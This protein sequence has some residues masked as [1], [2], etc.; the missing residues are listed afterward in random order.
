MRNPPLVLTIED[1]E[2]VRR[3]IASY[4]TD[5][6]Y[7][8]IEADNGRAGLQRI[9]MDKP[10]VVLCDLRMPELDGLFV[11]AEIAKFLPDT[12]VIVVSGTGDVQDAVHSLHLGAWDYIMKPIQDMAVLEDSIRKALERARLVAQNREYRDTL[13]EKNQQ[14]AHSLEKLEE[15]KNAADAANRAKGTFLANMSHEIRTPMNAIIGM[16]DLLADTPLNEEQRDFLDTIRISSEALLD[17]LNDILD[18]SKIESGKMDLEPVPFDLRKH[19]ERIV[20]TIAQQADAKN[21]ELGLLINPETPP[22]V[23]GDP[24]RIRQILLNLVNNA[25]KFTSEGEVVVHVFPEVSEG[26]KTTGKIRFEVSDTGIGIP[27]DRIP[28]LFQPFTQVDSS[29]TRRFGGTGLGLAISFRLTELMG[30]KIGIISELDRGSTFWFTIPLPETHNEPGIEYGPE[31]VDLRGTRV[32]VVDD[33]RTNRHILRT[34]LE[35]WGCAV[36]EAVS[37]GDALLM[38][39]EAIAANRPFRMALVDYQ[40]P[41]M[42]GET[43]TRTIKGDEA[44]KEVSVVLLTSV[45]TRNT[46]KELAGIGFEGALCKPLKQSMLRDCMTAILSLRHGASTGESTHFVTEATIGRS[47]LSRYRILV[48]EDV[49]PNQKVIQQLLARAGYQSVIVSNGREALDQLAGETF[50]L[51]LMDCQM[52]VM[53]GY[54]ATRRLRSSEEGTVRHT[55]VIAMTASVMKADRERCFSVGMDDFLSKPVTRTQ[56]FSTLQRWLDPGDHGRIDTC[57]P[58]CPEAT[59]VK[60]DVPPPVRLDYLKEYAGED[61]DFLLKLT[62]AFLE[63]NE[64]HLDSLIS[65]VEGSDA[66]MT[67]FHA[68]ALKNG[69]ETFK[70]QRLADMARRIEALAQAGGLSETPA[71]LPA[72][73]DDYAEV[74]RFLRHFIES[75]RP[76]TVDMSQ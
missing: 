3:S 47:A 54:E 24:G 68:H 13:L 15:A 76:D 43:L 9:L 57:A 48:A 39:R 26:E 50:D 56:L 58:P 4:L 67:A 53:D 62:R 36:A 31:P 34:Y 1:V 42:D 18:F 60:D 5:S 29:M 41:E 71:L 52:P 65:A 66:S 45:G 21:I 51:V 11:M 14:L 8:V 70:A 61:T 20:D 46:M 69:A 37:G 12:P 64:K 73:R 74:A 49:V 25:V 44:L 28:H 7:D 22:W 38:L 30:G 16:A 40:M 23:I 27:K 35:K 17:I 75:A 55:P 63:E 10:D 33:N 59:A 19:V 72:L 6:G 32:L 2:S